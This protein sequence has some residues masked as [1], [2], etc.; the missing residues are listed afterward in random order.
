LRLR[1]QVTTFCIYYYYY[2]DFILRN[3]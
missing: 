1:L 2:L 3:R